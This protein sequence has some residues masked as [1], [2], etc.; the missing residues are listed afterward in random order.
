MKERL[1]SRIKKYLIQKYSFRATTW[2]FR[3]WRM[4]RKSSPHE[5]GISY[6]QTKQSNVSTKMGKKPYGQLFLIDYETDLH[7]NM[8]DKLCP[9]LERGLFSYDTT[10]LQDA[11]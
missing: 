6:W 9:T 5:L 7:G 1:L 8:I 2:L 10:H 4:V 3:E 11:L